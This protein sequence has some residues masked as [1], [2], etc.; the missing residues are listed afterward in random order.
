MNEYYSLLVSIWIFSLNIKTEQ[1]EDERRFHSGYNY[2]TFPALQPWRHSN[3]NN[4]IS[5]IFFM[6][7]FILVIMFLL[8]SGQFG[9]FGLERYAK[10]EQASNEIK[11][12]M[13]HRASWRD[14]IFLDLHMFAINI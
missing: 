11:L 6:V 12:K 9:R 8:A 3:G 7:K 14:E 2:L 5:I 4:Y 13:E 10:Y 1:K